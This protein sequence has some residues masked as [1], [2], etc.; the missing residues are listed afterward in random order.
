MAVDESEG[1]NDN[2]GRTDV[3]PSEKTNS[4]AGNFESFM[5]RIHHGR[6][7][8][9]GGTDSKKQQHKPIR[10]LVVGD[11]LAGGV[12]SE[13]ASP[14]LPESI[15]RALSSALGGRAI[16]WTCIGTSGASAG[17]IVRDIESYHDEE[18]KKD[19]SKSVKTNFVEKILPWTRER[20]RA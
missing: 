9:T 12:G 3:W 16:H 5:R 19:A 7:T 8:N 11:S 20:I 18:N 4:R 6:N 14:V 17:R 15:A 13:S 2:G 10:L 1:R